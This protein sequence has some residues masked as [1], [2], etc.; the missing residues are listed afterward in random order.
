MW[1]CAGLM[2]GAMASRIVCVTALDNPMAAYVLPVSRMDA[3]AAGALVSLALRHPDDRRRALAIARWLGPVAAAVF[4]AVVHLEDP[5]DDGSWTEPL[6][7]TVGYT[8][9]ALLFASLVAV[10]AGGQGRSV[11]VRM[12]D[13]AP[14]RSAGKYSYALYLFHIPVRRWVRDYY[15][16]VSAFPTWLGSPLPGQLVFYVAATLPAILLAW[17]SWHAYEKQVLKLKRLFPYGRPGVGATTTSARV[18]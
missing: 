3:L 12:F 17:A 7:Q 8:A 2:A 14:L 11:A 4:A 6:M 5:F 13:V 15:F 1:T 9:L 10:V 16:P 18:P